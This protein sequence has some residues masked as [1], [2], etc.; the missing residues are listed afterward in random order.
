MSKTKIFNCQYCNKQL[1]NKQSLQRHTNICK[2][3]IQED[4]EIKENEKK[5]LKDEIKQLREELE[6]YKL[7]N[8]ILKE[9]EIKLLIEELEE[10]KLENARLKGEIEVY[11]S[12]GEFHAQGVMD[13]AKQPKHT[14]TNTTNYKSVVTFDLRDEEN[15]KD[16]Q[17]KVCNTFEEK[18]FVEGQKGVAKAVVQ[19]VLRNEEGVN[20]KYLCTDYAR[21][22][23]KSKDKYGNM[24]TD[25]KAAMLTNIV[26]IGIKEKV[27]YISKRCMDRE[28]D[29]LEKLV[30]ISNNTLD[31][32]KMTEDNSDFRKE[33]MS[34]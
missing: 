19:G 13:I 3:F 9:N 33:L 4:K 32:I 24:I 5:Q 15:I 29:N 34:N 25:P 17:N 20:K 23:F 6:E 27:G 30:C 18:H 31:I 2:V 12:Y 7:N 8:T 14:N 22:I 28:K 21:S 26:Y 11:K 16:I 1:F 10:Y